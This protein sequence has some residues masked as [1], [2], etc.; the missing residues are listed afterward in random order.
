MAVEARGRFF[1]L[2]LVYTLGLCLRITIL[3]ENLENNAIPPTIILFQRF[4][5]SL[6]DIVS[7]TVLSQHIFRFSIQVWELTFSLYF[8]V[9]ESEDF[10][11]TNI[12]YIKLKTRVFQNIQQIIYSTFIFKRTVNKLLSLFETSPGI[13]IAY[14]SKSSW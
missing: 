2:Y 6:R 1:P 10:L 12:Y 8:S 11:S 13:S 7:L 9:V 14:H 5:F 3:T 4:D